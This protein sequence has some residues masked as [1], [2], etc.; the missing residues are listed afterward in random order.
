MDAY[1]M[2][3]DDEA[4]VVATYRAL[5][6]SELEGQQQQQGQGQGQGQQ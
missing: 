5:L 1:D 2:E 3:L 6:A 4:E